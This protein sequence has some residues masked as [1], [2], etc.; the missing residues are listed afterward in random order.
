MRKVLSILCLVFLVGV[1]TYAQESGTIRGTVNDEDGTPLPG[2][3][4]TLSGSK[5]LTQTVITSERGNFRFMGLP[6]AQDYTLRLEIPGFNT[7]IREMLGVSFGRD[8]SLSLTL[9]QATLAEEITVVGESP[10][11]DTKRTQVGV[12]I[13]DDMIMSLPTSR[14]PWVIMSLVP[15]MLIDRED[16]GGNEGGQ[17][18][19]YFGHGGRSGDTTWNID[20]ASITDMSALGAAPAY[21][22]IASY[23]ELQINYG[24]ND[25]RSQ[26]GGVQLNLISKRGGNSYSGTFYMDAEMDSW[27][28]E[29]LTQE[30]KDIGYTSAGINRVYLYGANFGGP[31]IKDKLWFYGS[32]AIQD[33]DGRT[34][35]GGSDKTWLASGYAKLNAQITP[36][37]RVEGFVEF[38]DKSKWGR[39]AW[40]YTV[41]GPETLWNQTGP[42]YIW[43]GEVEQTAG[44]L[45]L[46]LKAV[47]MN[48]GFNLQPV[49][50]KHTADG[51]GNY[52]VIS[53][54]PSFFVSGNIDDYG[55]DRDSINLNLTG[56]YFA[57]GVLGGDHEIKFGVDYL[58]AKTTT[59]DY[60]EGNLNLVYYGPSAAMPNGQEW[61]AWLLRDYEINVWMRKFGAYI[62]DTMTFGKLAVNVGLRYDYEQ[63]M[64]KDAG[65]PASPWLP[66]YMPAL[67]VD[68]IDPGVTWSR[69]SPRMS[70]IYDITGDGKN[71]VKL[72]AARYGS[73]GGFDLAYFINPLGWTEIDLY[74]QD[75]NTDGRVTQNELWGY[76]WATD[77]LM[78]PNDPDYWLWSS[79]VNVADPKSVVPTR[80][81]D[82]NFNSPVLD[83]VTLSYEREIFADFAARLEFFYKKQH[84]EV[85]QKG[86]F[87]DGTIDSASNYYEAG[88][89]PVTGAT[90]YG[91][92][93][94][95]P[96]AYQTNYEKR[97]DRYLAG[98][99]VFKKRLSNKWMLDASFTYSDWRQFHEG[100]FLD[101][102][103]S[104]VAGGLNN[105]AYYD[106]GMVAPQSGGSGVRGIYVNSRWMAKIS[107]LY[108]MPFG[109]NLAG[110]FRARE[111]YIIP[112][113]ERIF[114]PGIGTRSLYGPGQFGDNRLPAFWMLDLRLEKVFNITDTSSVVLA[115]DAFNVTNSAHVLKEEPLL[116]APN[117]RDPL[118]ILNPRVI[119]FGVIFRF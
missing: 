114:M 106:G 55:C 82:P 30:M 104:S 12:N 84:T 98:Q 13:T 73:Q 40:G 67:S 47:Y 4:V 69:I 28:A 37:T 68:K 1:F 116:T 23:E 85:W 94:R 61:V 80:K 32:W 43:K 113:H 107:G 64:V 41:Q 70:L 24:N 97:Y 118:R 115:A 29:N 25:V 57:E 2:V 56:N 109:F 7:L 33:I 27:Q 18:S 112:T 14:N 90:Y 83:E 46:N 72:S 92:T 59:Y 101:F 42:G 71:V 8:T 52:M 5:V 20:G 102:A 79:G 110:V 89:G 21:V 81:F 15:G 88:T 95:A 35:S 44:S 60:Y 36:S 19:S 51:S 45:Y 96:Y 77:T 10:V 117:F 31:L 86:L 48:G 58:T 26:T 62:Q 66:T 75:A 63:S 65:I 111:G 53:Y 93:A 9:S 100:E 87:A 108:Q 119:R 50:G 11:I 3:T 22:N 39:S 74:W 6:V 99:L 76:D 105:A 38:D 103:T 16:V 17:Q 78:D 91:R 49:Q 54:Y 34:L